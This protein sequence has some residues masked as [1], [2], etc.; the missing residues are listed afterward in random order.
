MCRVLC[1]Q[2]QVRP[3]SSKRP[4]STTLM[5]S[6]TISSLSPYSCVKLDAEFPFPSSELTHPHPKNHQGGD[7]TE[8][9]TGE[10]EASIHIPKANHL[11]FRPVLHSASPTLPWGFCF[12]THTLRKAQPYCPYLAFLPIFS[13]LRQ[14][15]SPTGEADSLNSR[16]NLLGPTPG[17]P[18][19][20]VSGS[21]RRLS[22]SRPPLLIQG[23]G[24]CSG[25]ASKAHTACGE[26]LA[27][28]G[29]LCMGTI[30][31]ASPC[32]PAPTVPHEQQH[33][34]PRCSPLQRTCQ[35]AWPT[36]GVS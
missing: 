13:Q 8:G 17:L 23:M 7:V 27:H 3:L 25:A 5:P 28:G 30:G 18:C 15:Q 10:D 26:G 22:F 2:R 12:G 1:I 34:P 29:V 21:G 24:C 33:L 14:P 20:D 11:N 35:V 16:A 19:H 6:V 32:F 36:S 9:N 31:T 4:Q